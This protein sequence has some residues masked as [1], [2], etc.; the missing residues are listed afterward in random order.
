[1][2]HISIFGDSL[3]TYGGL[4]LPPGANAYL[5]ASYILDNGNGNVLTAISSAYPSYT[6]NNISRGGMT[7]DEA[8]TG[9]QTYVGPG[10]PN[11]FGS[12]VTIT[13]YLSN[14]RPNIAV[15]RYG[16]ADAILMNNANATLKNINTIV[17]HAKSLNVEV[18]LI[19][20]NPIVEATSAAY[21][22]PLPA[23]ST[24]TVTVNDAIQ[25]NLHLKAINDN[26]KFINPRHANIMDL[27]FPDGVH[28]FNTYGKVIT[29]EISFQAQSLTRFGRRSNVRITQQ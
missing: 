15:V 19:G 20:C 17:N 18:I 23:V 13:G 11:P 3:S 4:I 22:G 24:A 7:T 14:V 21:A 2:P 1:M 25:A 27:V 26:I 8:L 29:E 10:L 12:H 5:E 16:V 9:V 6:I 28:P